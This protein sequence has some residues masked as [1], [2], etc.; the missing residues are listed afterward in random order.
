MSFRFVAGIHLIR[1]YEHV[2]IP[3]LRKLWQALSEQLMSDKERF[4]DCLATHLMSSHYNGS[5]YPSGNPN[6]PVP[7]YGMTF[8]DAEEFLYYQ[9]EGHQDQRY[10][11][12]TQTPARP[13]RS[14]LQ[15][16]EGVGHF[17]PQTLHV[18]IPQGALPGTNPTPTS[19]FPEST[20]STTMSYPYSYLPPGAWNGYPPDVP[21]QSPIRPTF[22]CS[23]CHDRLRSRQAL[24]HHIEARHRGRRIPCQYCGATFSYRQALMR[25]WRELRC[26]S[27]RA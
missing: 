13:P 2:P 27:L 22:E 16:G 15:Y 26:P 19:A 5:Q 11:T 7:W 25:H 6:Q 10:L 20:T 14:N 3:L 21:Q 12:Q 17:Q 1:P 18:D 4:E 9:D 24:N 23:E 8:D